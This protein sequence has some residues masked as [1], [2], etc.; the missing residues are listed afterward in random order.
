MAILHCGAQLFL[1]EVNV[2]SAMYVYFVII[3]VSFCERGIRL[4]LEEG[5]GRNAQL[6]A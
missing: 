3:V 4:H 5:L 6:Y 1:M 2:L